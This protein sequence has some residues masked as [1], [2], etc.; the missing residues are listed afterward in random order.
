MDKTIFIGWD[1]RETEAFDVAI[2][3]IRCRT[4]ED[5]HFVPLKLQELVSDGLLSRPI[6][7]KD[8]KMWCPISQAPMATEFAI[9]RFSVPLLKQSG[10]ALFMDCDIVCLADISELFALADPKY[11]VQVVKHDYTPT[12]TV[13]MDGQV[14]TTYSRK[15]WSSVVLWNCDHPSNKKLTAEVLNSWPGRDLHAFKWLADEEIGELPKE[16]NWLVGV[17]PPGPQKLLHFTNGGPWLPNWKGGPLDHIW[18]R[19]ALNL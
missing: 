19:E 3:S 17:Y 16:W 5:Y 8:G 14:Q 9:S 13:K 2:A 1:S 18:E 15:N 12:D 10:L 4:K 7:T 6:E 11:A